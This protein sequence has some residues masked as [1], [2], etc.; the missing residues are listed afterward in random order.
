LEE[1]EE[2]PEADLVEGAVV[3]SQEADHEA[4]FQEAEIGVLPVAV[5]AEETDTVVFHQIQTDPEVP[6]SQLQDLL[7]RRKISKDKSSRR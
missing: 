6:I 7:A 5:L 4:D 1:T 2:V 3:V